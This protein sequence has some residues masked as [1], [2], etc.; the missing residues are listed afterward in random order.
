MGVCSSK[1]PK[2]DQ[3]AKTKDSLKGIMKDKDKKNAGGKGLG[4]GHDGEDGKNEKGEHVEGEKVKEVQIKIGDKIEKVKEAT[5]KDKPVSKEELH[6]KNLLEQ[7]KKA[8][9]AKSQTDKEFDILRHG[10]KIN[11]K[12]SANNAS[13]PSI[14]P[15][16]ETVAP[17][18]D[19]GNKMQHESEAHKLTQ[20]AKEELKKRKDEAMREL[21]REAI[22]EDAK[23]AHAK[24]HPIIVTDSIKLR[25]K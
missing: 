20:K 19:E 25:F 10:S 13:V 2:N 9:Q 21:K 22:E 15:I 12:K 4:N 11:D 5:G 23:I 1:K 14:K 24:E 7:D 16:L 18:Y 17:I 8:V 6:E 3:D